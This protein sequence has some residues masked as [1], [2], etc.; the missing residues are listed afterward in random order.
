MVMELNDILRQ[1][2]CMYV[3]GSI[4]T[5]FD[6]FKYIWVGRQN[7]SFFSTIHSVLFTS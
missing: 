6:L 3:D 7:Y 2:G 4:I 1:R 5:A